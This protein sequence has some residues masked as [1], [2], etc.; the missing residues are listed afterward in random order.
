[1]EVLRI[2]LTSWRREKDQFVTLPRSSRMLRRAQGHEPACA[3]HADAHYAS[4]S[5]CCQRVGRHALPRTPLSHRTCCLPGVFVRQSLQIESWKINDLQAATAPWSAMGD[6]A[7]PGFRVALLLAW[8]L[9]YPTSELRAGRRE[10]AHP[11]PIRDRMAPA[12]SHHA[13]RHCSQFVEGRRG[14]TGGRAGSEEKRRFSASFDVRHIV[15]N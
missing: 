12:R 8:T 15:I 2:G 1:L 13:S 7:V 3:C 10:E 6:R 9:L 14:C 11:E 5:S 4:L